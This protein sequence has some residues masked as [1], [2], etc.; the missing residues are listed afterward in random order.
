M[1]VDTHLY[2]L[3]VM[4]FAV[5]FPVLLSFDKKVNFQQYFVPFI[6]SASIVALFFILGDI[7]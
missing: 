3:L 7:L 2:Y 5:A 1:K 4:V 6:K